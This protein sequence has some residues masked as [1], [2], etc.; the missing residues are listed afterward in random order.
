[1]LLQGVKA[2][3]LKESDELHGLGAV[4]VFLEA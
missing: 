3:L 2:V 1:M 4:S